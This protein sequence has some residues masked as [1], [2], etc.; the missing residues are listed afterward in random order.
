MWQYVSENDDQVAAGCAPGWLVPRERGRE[1]DAGATAGRG[2][3]VDGQGAGNAERGHQLDGVTHRKGAS[4]EDWNAVGDAPRADSHVEPGRERG[5]E[6]VTWHEVGPLHAAARVGQ[7]NRKVL[8]QDH[9]QPR[10]VSAVAVA[11]DADVSKT[12]AVGDV[13]GRGQQGLPRASLA[14]CLLEAGEVDVHVSAG[15]GGFDEDDVDVD[16]GSNRE[17][18]RADRATCSH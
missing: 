15:G 1:A 14:G 7:T 8:S 3:T 16:V 17:V 2:C 11:D 5:N 12:S 10:F 13:E 6:F 4:H 9:R 18:G